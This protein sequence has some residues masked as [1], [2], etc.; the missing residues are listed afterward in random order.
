MKDEKS[1]SHFYKTFPLDPRYKDQ[2]VLIDYQ[3]E[4]RFL[5][6]GINFHWWGNASVTPHHHNFF[7][8]V[9][10]AESSTIHYLNGEKSMLYLGTLTMIKEGDTHWHFPADG[11]KSLHLTLGITREKLKTLCVALAPDL[12]ETLTQCPSF[13]IMLTENEQSRI[14]NQARRIDYIVDPTQTHSLEKIIATQTIIDILFVLFQ[15]CLSKNDVLPAWFSDLLHKMNT[16]E[17]LCASIPEIAQL[18]NY[19]PKSLV[20]YFR[21]YT[22]DTIIAYQNKLKVNYAC[23]LLANTTK[24]TLDIANEL[25]YSSLTAFN[26]MFKKYTGMTPKEYRNS[27]KRISQTSAS[28]DT[29]GELKTFESE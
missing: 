13:T 5:D 7:E 2:D 21:K 26:C 8:F 24:T 1:I 18:A 29:E 20:S 17:Y 28:H 19:S 15:S 23:K 22:G 27:S 25:L 10:V 3:K 12:Y 9:Y 6:A 14:M 11:S 16:P 4:F